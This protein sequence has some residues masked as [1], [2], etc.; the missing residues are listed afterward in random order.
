MLH[1]SVRKLHSL[2]ASIPVALALAALLPGTADAQQPAT[3][4][5][6]P[7]GAQ[8]A[9]RTHTVRPGDTL[10]GLA[11]QYLG[12]PFLWPEIY[13]LNTM[14]VE[15]PH[16]IYPGEV[17]RLTGSAAVSAVPP[18]T[19]PA[20]AEAP[21]EV[22]AEASTAEADAPAVPTSFR[23]PARAQ[24]PIVTGLETP[25]AQ[26][27]RR[28]EFYS[29]GFLTENRKLPFGK[30]RGGV[31]PWQIAASDASPSITLFTAVA[32]QPPA[33]AKYQIGD[34]L[35]VGEV[36]GRYDGYGQAF[37][38]TGL[39]R[40]TGTPGGKYVATVVAVFGAMRS[41]QLVLPAQPYPAVSDAA[42]VPVSDGVRA[43]VL[44]TAQPQELKGMQDVLF[45]DK[46]SRE[47]VAPGDLFEV[48]RTPRTTA[49]GAERIDELMAVLQVV[50]VGEHTATT[51][52]VRVISPDIPVGTTAR[53]TAK[54]PG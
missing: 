35:L 32:V 25:A 16:W 29:S 23:G 41:G 24:A 11:Q 5:A 10:W 30:L 22:P 9:D 53:Q 3:P 39:L 1:P 54:Q 19:T 14:V 26:P 38:P 47:G 18:D 12:D 46:G 48:R 37:R 51:R 7:A 44:G 49:A 34:S 4:A 15:D 27:L 33:G 17:L 21:A 45:L 40:V 8:P 50:R 20:P 31:T 2:V 36:G 52:I 28:G 6:Q 13:R 42:P 43:R